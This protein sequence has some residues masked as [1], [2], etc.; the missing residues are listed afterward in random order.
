MHWEV[1][2]NKVEF[3]VEYENA[4][5]DCLRRGWITEGPQA[6]AFIQRIR[7][8]SGAAHVALAPN[9]TLAL[10]LALRAVGVG[11]GDEVVVP[12]LTFIASAT[13]V[14]MT[15]A[16]PVFVDVDERG[17]LSVPDLDR[18]MRERKQRP[19]AVMPVHLFGFLA[20]S[21][22]L[23]A[24]VVEDACQAFGCMSPAAFNRIQVLSFFAD[25]AFTTGEGGAVLTNDAELAERMRY[26]R[27]QG[28]LDRGSFTHPEVGINLRMT[29][30]Q[31]AIGNVQLRHF[32]KVSDL[33]R[34]AWRKYAMLFRRYAT[35]MHVLT[36]PPDQLPSFIPFRTI[37]VFHKPVAAATA[38]VMRRRGRV[39]PREMFVPL[40]R[41]PCFKDLHDGCFKAPYVGCDFPGTDDLWQR[42]LLLPCWPA[43][44]PE[45]VDLVV[46]EV[47]ASYQEALR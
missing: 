14:L 8:I 38:A 12:D 1:P 5:V 34:W 30:L 45:Q 40:H 15:G 37:V 16:K 23:D 18:L 20:P 46:E 47:A 26:I 21:V 4:V 36:P 25:K 28:R 27:N 9:G 3:S 2:Q 19:K 29:D 35:E 31:C 11:P 43:M 17:L 24:T 10:Y 39:E 42:S 7:D 13:A 41:Q 22:D 32:S 33:R 44:T 6:E